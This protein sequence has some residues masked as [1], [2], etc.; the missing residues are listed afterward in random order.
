MDDRS[1]SSSSSTDLQGGM[2]PPEDLPSNFTMKR[3]ISEALLKLTF[4]D[5]T[6]IEEEI[7]GVRCVAR[8]EPPEF[9]DRKLREFDQLLMEIKRERIERAGPSIYGGNLNENNDVLRNVRRVYSDAT[10]TSENLTSASASAS[11]STSTST[12]A[13]SPV[14]A[15]PLLSA[16]PSP[17]SSSAAAAVA[18]AEISA[19]EEPYINSNRNRNAINSNTCYLNI[20]EVRIR[21]LRSKLYDTEEAVIA[22]ITFLELSSDIFG[23]YVADRPIQISDFKTGKEKAALR[24]SRHQFVP[25]L[26]RA[27]RRILVS[28]G[29]GG[30]HLNAKLMLKIMIYMLWSGS[31]DAETQRR[32]IVFVYWPTFDTPNENKFT[33]KQSFSI[34]E[35][36]I[37]PRMT[38]RM[39]GLYERLA[40]SSIVRF[41]SIH[42]CMEDTPPNRTL[43]N[44]AAFIVAPQYR[45]RVKRHFG[46]FVELKYALTGFGIPADLIPLSHTGKVKTTN[47]LRCIKSLQLQYERKNDRNLPSATDDK[48]EIM[49]FPK[50]YDVFFHKGQRFEN[51]PGNIVFHGLIDSK[52]SEL[53]MRSSGNGSTIATEI[54]QEIEQQGGR[55]LELSA[56]D[57]WEVKTDRTSIISKVAAAH[58]REYKRKIA[59]AKAAGEKQEGGNVAPKRRKSCQNC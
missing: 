58:Y 50:F 24:N 27:G 16:P 53:P 14:P 13:P 9:L 21:F 56:D 43:S 33:D 8:A 40:A 11:V 5:R 55:F 48:E 15:S 31:I 44:F 30:C 20:P 52:S 45:P 54:I 18:A 23:D 3:F 29:T 25:Y 38:R 47:H 57:V 17:V 7:H 59:R 28:V 19:G 26:D 41:S 22:L 46:G 39:I 4:E 36:F 32:G 10:E 37:R 6:A 2:E 35:S 12:S 51:N 1:L 49:V 34:W 42:F